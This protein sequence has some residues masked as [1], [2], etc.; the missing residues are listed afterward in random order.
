MVGAVGENAT[1]RTQSECPT[2]DKPFRDPV[3]RSRIR[4]VPSK[5]PAAKVAASGEKVTPNTALLRPSKTAKQAAEA[6]SHRRTVLSR[7]PLAIIA[8]VDAKDTSQTQ[9]R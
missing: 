7:E 3:A 8:P 5:E 6:G 9:S 2:I 4:I 1:L